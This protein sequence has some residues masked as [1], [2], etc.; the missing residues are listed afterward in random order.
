L[1]TNDDGCLSDGIMYLRNHL[2]DQFDVTIVAPDR[3]RSAISMALTLNDPL[4]IDYIEEKVIAI[5]GTPV[6]C[7]NVAIQK[8]LKRKPD[9][10]ISGMNFGENLSEDIF[11]SGTVGGAFAGFLYGIPSMAVSLIPGQQ[12]D[13]SLLFDVKNGTEITEEILKRLLNIKNNPVVYNVNIPFKNNGKILITSMGYKR[14]KPEIIE[15]KDPRGKKYYWIGAGTPVYH[16]KKGTDIWAIKNEYIS[17]STIH[18]DL[19]SKKHLKTITGL[20]DKI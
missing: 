17:L 6:D 8:I 18:Y 19:N 5:D 4:R 2:A 15:K 16:G 14:Y 12:S 11:F 7:I 9:F 20:F 13:G 10:I 3:E 1:L